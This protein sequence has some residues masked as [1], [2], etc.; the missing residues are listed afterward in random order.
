SPCARSPARKSSCSTSRWNPPSKTCARNTAT[1]GSDFVLKGEWSSGQS[2]TVTLKA[3]LP[4]DIGQ[5]L[6]EDI[7]RE[8]TAEAVSP[9]AGF[10][11]EGKFYFPPADGAGRCFWK[12]VTS[13]GLILRSAACSR[14]TC[15]RP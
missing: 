1:T 11:H 14:T 13:R 15:P 8:V 2:Y 4:T 12:P 9:Y 6:A 7:T 5:T 10:P 3:G